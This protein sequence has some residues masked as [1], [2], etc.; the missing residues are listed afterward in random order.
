MYYYQLKEN[1]LNTNH[2]ISQE[3]YFELAALALQADY[4]NFNHEIHKGSY[5]DI[6]LYF[7]KWVCLFNGK[8]L[9]SILIFQ[10][11]R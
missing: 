5:V 4:G 3:R 9:I 10:I 6:N 1:F 8:F 7:P 2:S 11:N